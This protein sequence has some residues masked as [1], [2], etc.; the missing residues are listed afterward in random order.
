MRRP[1]DLEEQLER[2]RLAEVYLLMGPAEYLIDRFVGRLARAAEA[3]RQSLE[4]ADHT[5]D[6]VRTGYLVQDLFA[7]SRLVHVRNVQA[8]KPNQRKAFLESV[9]GKLP[10]GLRVVLTGEGKKPSTAKLPPEVESAFY[11]NPFPSVLPRLA[12]TFLRDHGARPARGTGDE[13]VRLYGNDLRRIDQE[14]FKLAVSCSG[15]PVDPEAVRRLCLPASGARSFLVAATITS[16]R[17]ARSL[18]ELRELLSGET[19]HALL[20]ILAGRLR[21]M[22]VLRGLEQRDR[23]RWQDA[24][25]VA[26]ELTR[27]EEEP[28]RYRMNG[29][30]RSALEKQ[31]GE[32]LDG[33]TPWERSELE[34]VHPRQ[35]PG[36]V[37]HAARFSG[38]EL[39]DGLRACARADRE[40]KGE[41]ADHDLVM[42]RLVH[43][44]TRPPEGRSPR[45]PGRAPRGGC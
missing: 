28:G 3:R 38:A 10:P 37:D 24:L 14:A 40:L 29:R 11:W 20:A 9:A 8:W 5:P 6:E 34:S 22:G 16:R 41:A 23:R 45:R 43:L 18:R 13:L 19:P 25:D 30:Q 26:G 36:L 33:L 15:K 35:L 27:A 31:V 32:V 1:E 21:R 44:L 12:E 17:R 7:T 2:G 4:A 39:A 42:E